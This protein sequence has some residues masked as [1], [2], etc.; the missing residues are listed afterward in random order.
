MISASGLVNAV[1]PFRGSNFMI[2]KFEWNIP[3]SRQC[4][5]RLGPVQAHPRTAFLGDRPPLRGVKIS[6]KSIYLGM[7]VDG[8]VARRSCDLDESPSERL[9]FYQS[10]LR[11]FRFD[12]S[13]TEE[14][15]NCSTAQY[16]WL[17]SQKVITAGNNGMERCLAWRFG[18]A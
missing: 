4:R 16:K 3:K 12:P 14:E 2:K 5:G 13:K 8:V 9:H 15:K 7:S 6:L 10:Q 11:L 18:F 17:L 1:Q